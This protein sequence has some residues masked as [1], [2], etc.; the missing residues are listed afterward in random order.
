MRNILIYFAIK[1]HG[2]YQKILNAIKTK[3]KVQNEDL[4]KVKNIKALT[5]IDENYPLS[6]KNC[7]IFFCSILQY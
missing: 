4:Q 7:Y 5:I 2:D 6:L 3:E 1:Y